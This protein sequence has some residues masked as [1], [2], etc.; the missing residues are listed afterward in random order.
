MVTLVVPDVDDVHRLVL[1]RGVDLVEAPRNL[2]YGQ[3]RM[4]LR[5]PIGTLVDV[6]SECPPAPEFLASLRG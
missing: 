6:S 2:F 4:L 3:R 1:E 5:D